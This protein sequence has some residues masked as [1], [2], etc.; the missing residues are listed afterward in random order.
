MEG[1]P[2]TVTDNRGFWLTTVLPLLT[3]E[4]TLAPVAA[5]AAAVTV[6]VLVGPVIE[7]EARAAL[8]AATAAARSFILSRMPGVKVILGFWLGT[9]CVILTGFLPSSVKISVN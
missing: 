2:E 1:P 6:A 3:A 5:V 7:D 9:K 8:A 4:L